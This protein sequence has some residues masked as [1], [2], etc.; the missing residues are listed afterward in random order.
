VGLQQFQASPSTVIPG[1]FQSSSFVPSMYD[2][3]KAPL[4]Y[5]PA[6]LGGV[7]PCA[8]GNRR[9]V[10]PRNPSVL[11][12]VAL[13]GQI[14]PGTGEQLN[15]IV[16]SGDPGYP[17]ELVD[18]QGILPA[19]RLGFS[20][21]V[22]GDG[23]TAIRGGF[24]VNYNPRN[25]GGN[26]G[27]MQ[28]NP[29]NV[30]QPVVR[31][32]TTANFLA[33]QGTFSPP[34]F[35]R[36]L[37]RDNKP[38][39][40]YNTSLG[41]QRRLPWQFVIDVSYVGSFNRHIGAITQLNNVP[42]GARF[43]AANLDPTR[44]SPQALPD[45]LLRPYRGYGGI[46]FLTF[47]A[48]SNYHAL[49]TSLQRRFSKGFQLGMVYTWSKAMD[50]QDGDKDDVTTANDRRLWNY[51]LSLYDRT[52]I[53][54]ANY[55]WNL[56]GDKIGN[57]FLKG[58]VGGWQVSGITRWQ[59]GAPL[60]LAGSLRTGCSIAGAPCANTT[61]N[62]FGTD[63]TGGSEGW[64]P[65]VTGNPVLPRDQRTVDRWF[66]TTV[67]QPPALAQ[68]VTN[69]AGVQQ[70]LDRGNV[71]RR[72]A[73]RGPGLFNTDLA[74]FKNINLAG[75]LKAQL[76]IE[77]YNVFNHTQFDTVNTTAQWDQ[78]GAQVNPAFGKV[79]GARDPRIV[80]L[81]LQLKF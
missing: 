42:Y 69:M 47:D 32:G 20:W 36:T 29:P 46:P 58:I 62:N 14:V 26:T 21:D 45:E 30:Y 34:G 54:A 22:F 27:D 6:C 68:Q 76:R 78:S 9:A 52:H 72:I 1:R 3:A 51:G 12:P 18:F 40:A 17:R 19:P 55:L 37:N 13:V 64:R 7:N 25:N 35:S 39:V 43:Q 5:R 74:L 15:G 44:Q 33:S 63:I 56:P 61:A 79:T 67:F 2:P 11:L 28:S 59:S 57:G 16:V 60:S 53:F 8:A 73:A 71:G 80:Q 66:D 77:A 4:L 31:Y 38:S 41:V 50:Y 48:N 65:V 81:G 23:G 49:Q 24:G 75:N 70:V 10:D